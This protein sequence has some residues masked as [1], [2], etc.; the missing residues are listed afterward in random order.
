MSASATIVSAASLPTNSAS[1]N[2]EGEL[3]SF[4]GEMFDH[5]SRQKDGE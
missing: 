4:E 3:S 5:R 1:T 2:L